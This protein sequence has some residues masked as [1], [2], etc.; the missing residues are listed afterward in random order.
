MVWYLDFFSKNNSFIFTEK[1]NWNLDD[2]Y[3][4]NSENDLLVNLNPARTSGVSYYHRLRL[5]IN[6]LDQEFLKCSSEIFFFI[7][8]GNPAEYFL[9]DPRSF[10]TPDTYTRIQITPFV[11]KMNSDL[12]WRSSEVRKCYLHNERK[13]SIFQQYTQMNCNYECVFNETFTICGCISIE[14]A[15]LA[16]SGV[17]I[18]GLA[19]KDCMIKVKRKYIF[20]PT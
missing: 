5:M 3:P 17:N 13:L 15:F 1:S 2:G 11:K 14:M 12:R 9:P 10:I 8:L 16:P 4:R 6:M 20:M 19:K 7:T 18:C